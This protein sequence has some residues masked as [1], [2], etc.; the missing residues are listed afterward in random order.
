MPF[1]EFYD[2]YLF[3]DIMHLHYFSSTIQRT[4]EYFVNYFKRTIQKDNE[5]ISA[6]SFLLLQ[7]RKWNNSGINNINAEFK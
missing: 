5:Y 4:T 3:N 7:Q 1:A 6:I 2:F